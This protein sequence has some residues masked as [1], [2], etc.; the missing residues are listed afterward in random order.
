MLY[1]AGMQTTRQLITLIS[2]IWLTQSFAQREGFFIAPEVATGYSYIAN[3]YH[4]DALHA[5]AN[6]GYNVMFQYGGQ[7]GYK[8][9]R[10]GLKLGAYGSHYS[11]NLKQNDFTGDLTTE[12]FSYS[13]E[14][15]YQ[16]ERIKSS[17]YYHTVRL[18]YQLN[19]PRE[20]HYMSKNA[21]DATVYADQNQID[22]LQNDH[23]ITAAYGISTGYKLLWA[24]FSLR[25]GYSLGN[26]YKPLTATKG[27]NFFIGFGLAFGLFLN[28]NK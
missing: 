11:Q 9:K 21:V 23:M 15:L 18:G 7:A 25:M 12:Y 8:F 1:L 16:I 14:I 20:A 28:T 10:W 17:H 22:L 27:K 6:R 3:V 4:P 13:A 26:I 24:D 2:C 19:T 5:P